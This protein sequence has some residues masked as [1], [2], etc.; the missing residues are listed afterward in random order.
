VI[1]VDASVAIAWCLADESDEYAEQMLD[2]VA[3]EGA[4]APAHWPVEVANGILSAER[5]GRLDADEVGRVSRLLD[6]LAVDVVPVELSTAMW[7]IL[8]T[9]RELKL[10]VYDAAYIDLAKFRRLALATLDGPMRDL[11]ERSGVAL[12]S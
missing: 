2:R 6:Q 8:P 7:S 5:R 9:A 3:N 11:A 1:V 4:A 10:S 12:A